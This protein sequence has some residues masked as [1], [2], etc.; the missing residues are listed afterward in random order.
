MTISLSQIENAGYTLE[1]FFTV[2]N[3]TISLFEID[4]G[5]TPNDDE[6][7]QIIDAILARKVYN[8]DGTF[9]DA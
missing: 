6:H 7:Q 1:D 2:L 5:Y 8:A 3:L 9:L 4:R